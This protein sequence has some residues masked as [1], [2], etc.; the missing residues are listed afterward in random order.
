MGREDVPVAFK[1]PKT[2]IE[3][4]PLNLTSTPASIVRL[5]PISTVILPSTQY[6]LFARV[7]VVSLEMLPLTTVSASTLS[8]NKDRNPTIL[9][10]INIPTNKIAI[11]RLIL[12]PH[13]V[14]YAK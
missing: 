12:L 11:T 5:T 10:Q 2:V 7:H 8:I 4:D 1:V 13:W 14:V 6:G 3:K 9:A